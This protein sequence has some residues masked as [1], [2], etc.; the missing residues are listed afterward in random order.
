MRASLLWTPGYG[1]IPSPCHPSLAGEELQ[2]VAA[3]VVD[4]QLGQDVDVHIGGVEMDTVQPRIAVHQR[5]GQ[6]MAHADEFLGLNGRRQKGRPFIR[7]QINQNI[8]VLL[9]QAAADMPQGADRIVL[10][11]LSIVMR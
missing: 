1:R 10:P 11:F 8:I 4:A 3:V 5:A 6:E 9:M 7:M 2:A